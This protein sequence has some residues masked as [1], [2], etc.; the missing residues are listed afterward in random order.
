MHSRLEELGRVIVTE[1]LVIVTIIFAMQIY[2]GEKLVDAFRTRVS[3]AVA[4][5]PQGLQAVVKLTLAIGLQCMAAKNAL[6]RNLSS[7]ETLGCVNVICTDNTATLTR[8]EMTVRQWWVSR[9]RWQVSG[10]GVSPVGEPQ[11]TCEPAS[12]PN[13]GGNRA[14]KGRAK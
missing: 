4:A 7:V 2:R 1:C 10:Q 5:V 3:P 13:A 9:N 14:I 8:N 12:L 11:W 6:I